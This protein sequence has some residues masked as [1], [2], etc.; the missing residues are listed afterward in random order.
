MNKKFLID[1]DV[2]IDF[3]RGV[4]KAVN[5]IKSHSEEIVL[6]VITIAEL[7]AGMKEGDE[8]KELDD[9]LD[10]FPILTVTADIAKTGG[11]YKRDFARSHGV[12]LADGLMAAT[13]KNQDVDLKTLN[14]KHY[15]MFKGLKAPYSKKSKVRPDTETTQR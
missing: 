10:L 3:L 4:D 11:L 9:F 2:I 14:I 13:A 6:S 1:T 12:G 5:Y 7:Y 15:P 8:R